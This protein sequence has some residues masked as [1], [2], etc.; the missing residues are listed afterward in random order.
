VDFRK[1]PILDSLTPFTRILFLILLVITCFATAFLIGLLLAGPL[2]GV[3][4]K[5]IVSTL[6]DYSD[7]KTLRL[8]QYFQVIQSFGLF[9]IPSLLAGYFFERSSVRYLYIDRPSRWPV[10]V[11]TLVLMFAFLPFINWMVTVN[12]AMKLPDFLKGVEEWMKIAEDEAATLT[13][14]FMKMPDFG[15]FLFNLFMI[16]V[17]PAIGEEFMFRG[18]LQRLFKEWLGN[19]HVAI[20]LSAF[21]FSAMHFQFYGFF[22]RMI[23]GI[24]FGYMF[25]WSGSLWVPVCAHFINNGAAVVFSFLEQQGIL[26]GDYESFGATENGWFIMLSGLAV[27]AL[28]YLIYRLRPQPPAPFSPG[29]APQPP[30]PSPPGKAPQPPAP[31][32]QGEGE[33]PLLEDRVG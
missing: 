11:V 2:F 22:P 30:A 23:L 8:L 7:A 32:P 17:L 31:S 19:V 21:L 15:A 9:I 14:A 24:I 28:M 18:L 6:S 3:Q 29:K 16:A 10:Y 25:Y 1:Q 4:M 12:S 26:S 27:P 13:E 20:F 33:S 5:D